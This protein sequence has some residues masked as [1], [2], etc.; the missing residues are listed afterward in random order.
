MSAFKLIRA[1]GAIV[2]EGKPERLRYKQRCPV[3]AGLPQFIHMN[4]YVCSDPANEGPPIY[5]N[6][7]SIP[8]F[9]QGRLGLIE[10][11]GC[12]ATC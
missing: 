2:Q 11:R 3:V 6:G 12:R 9:R 7:K 10:A 5:Q 4:V 8:A 1:K